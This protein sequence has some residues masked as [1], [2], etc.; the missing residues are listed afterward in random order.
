MKS[1]NNDFLP[2]TQITLKTLQNCCLVV[3]TLAHCTELL[4][5]MTDLECTSH[6]FSDLTAWCQRSCRP[7]QAELWMGCIPPSPEWQCQQSERTAS[8][9]LQTQ[10]GCP[11]ERALRAA[12][13]TSTAQLLRA[14]PEPQL[15]W[16]KGKLSKLSR[17]ASPLA[18]SRL[19]K[20]LHVL[21][22]FLLIRLWM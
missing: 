21:M 4:K 9:A 10:P 5:L 18:Y 1:V 6:L 2:L 7:S 15:P 19:L 12:S 8:P 13:L 3:T 17:E 16:I 20:I 14:V 22:T 11:A